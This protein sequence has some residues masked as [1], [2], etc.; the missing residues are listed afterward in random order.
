MTAKRHKGLRAEKLGFHVD[1]PTKALT[2]RVAP[3]ERRTL[4]TAN[5]HHMAWRL[6][7]RQVLKVEIGGC[8]GPQPPRPTFVGRHHLSDG[9]GFPG[10]PDCSRLFDSFT[11]VAELRTRL[12]A[13]LAPGSGLS[14]R[15]SGRKGALPSEGRGREFESRRVRQ[16]LPYF[17]CFIGFLRCF[18]GRPQYGPQ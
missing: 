12:P 18:V 14:I 17:P 8:G 4:S 1:E 7:L 5:L 13:L 2:E 3:L 11:T 6:R 15:Q 9:T 16:I 10:E